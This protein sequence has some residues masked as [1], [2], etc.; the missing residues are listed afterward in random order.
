VA[1]YH[2][3]MGLDQ[4]EMIGMRIMSLGDGSKCPMMVFVQTTKMLISFQNKNKVK[5]FKRD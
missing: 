1:T 4:M 5:W 3:I 2:K